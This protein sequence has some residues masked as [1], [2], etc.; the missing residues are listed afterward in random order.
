MIISSTNFKRISMNNIKWAMVAAITLTM[1]VAKLGYA[2]PKEL[3]TEK[4]SSGAVFTGIASFDNNLQPVS[5]D[6]VLKGYEAG[7]AGFVNN[8]VSESISFV[9]DPTFNY[10]ATPIASNWWLDVSAADILGG[11]VFNSIL[12]TIDFTNPSAPV[13]TAADNG[14]NT[15]SDNA[16][17]LVSGTIQA[18]P[19]PA[20]IALISVGVLGMAARFGRPKS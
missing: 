5:I 4:F 16:D 10:G 9:F 18:V 3:I 8:S 2:Y 17:L 6:G 19:E 20:T 1:G 7:V 15:I 11:S 12:F 13:F 14:I